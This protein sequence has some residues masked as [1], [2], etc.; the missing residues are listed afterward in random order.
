RDLLSGIRTEA[1]EASD[2]RGPH[3]M[4]RETRSLGLPPPP[5]IG[6]L[7]PFRGEP[8]LQ[9]FGELIS[10][11]RSVLEG[12]EHERGGLLFL[13]A[14]ASDPSLVVGQPRRHEPAEDEEEF[15]RR[16]KMQCAPQGPRLDD[17]PP[18]HE[19][20]L[21]VV[22]RQRADAG[23]GG[24]IRRSGWD[25]DELPSPE[26]IERPSIHDQPEY[27]GG[28]AEDVSGNLRHRER[29]RDF[30]WPGREGREREERKPYH[31][32][33]G[34]ASDAES[35]RANGPCSG[36]TV[37]QSFDDPEYGESRQHRQDDVHEGERR[38]P[39]RIYGDRRP[40]PR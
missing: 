38:V 23:K 27:D 32:D 5:T 10:G 6:P 1:H 16:M 14:K 24:G 11:E 28:S 2:D 4:P 40:Q 22:D 25:G 19:R 12:L 36:G 20:P 7:F 31:R 3:E 21:D 30:R 39:P 33:G 15:L 29:E 34:R 8:L 18:L 17:R 37:E 13:Q 35:E 26:P 9:K